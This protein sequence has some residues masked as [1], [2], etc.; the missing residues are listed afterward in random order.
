MKTLSQAVLGRKGSRAAFTLA[1]VLIAM[2][3]SVMLGGFVLAC[4]LFG[5]RTSTFSNIKL[6]AAESVRKT[7]AFLQGDIRS[8][9]TVRVGSGTLASFT[10][11]ASN[12]NQVGNSIQITTS[13]DGSQWVRYYYT[14]TALFRTVDQASS[15][16]VATNLNA[17]SIPIF[18]LQRPTA[19]AN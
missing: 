13:A 1:E 14:N 2:S 4:Q 10:E 6:D 18:T 16:L 17:N 9:Y 5:L 3:L 7:V 12:T 11:V 8:A 19:T 15:D